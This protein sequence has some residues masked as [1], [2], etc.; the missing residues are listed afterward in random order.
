MTITIK[1]KKDKEF[2][3]NT[4]CKQLP[5]AISHKDLHKLFLRVW[6]KNMIIYEP[7]NSNEFE[8]RSKARL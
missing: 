5:I 4:I 7:K 2:K 3:R 6:P 1:R 8:K